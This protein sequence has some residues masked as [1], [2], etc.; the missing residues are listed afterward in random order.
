[1]T[2]DDFKFDLNSKKVRISD[3]E[4][5]ASV[6]EYAEKVNYRYFPYIEYDNWKERGAHSS[7]LMRR[8]GSW[9][10]VLI[11][12]GI[13]GGH[14]HTY[15]PQKLMDNLETVWREV[16]FPPGKGQLAKYGQKITEYPYVRI[17]GS[18]YHACE[19]L[20]KYH[21]GKITKD[22]LLMGDVSSKNTRQTIPLKTRWA[23][24]KRDNYKCIKCGVSPAK[25]H[26]TELEIDHIMPVAKGGKN[27]IDNLQTLCRNCNQGKK[28][29]I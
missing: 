8:F 14:E 29:R 22:E 15:G 17:W 1:M 7:T 5:L 23:V 19:L 24:L 3:D 28:D 13:E 4:L 6:K 10:K 21:D 25:D 2:K 11:L 26:Q 20:A 27:E 18:V 12:L 16:K 9:N